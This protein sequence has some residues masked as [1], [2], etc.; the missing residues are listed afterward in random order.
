MTVGAKWFSYKYESKLES[1][2]KSE[3]EVHV[4]DRLGLVAMQF[5]I[6]R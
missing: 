5:A 2:M 4:R 6:E 1:E 3:R